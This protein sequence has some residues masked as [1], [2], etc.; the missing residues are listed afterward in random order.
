MQG[1]QLQGVQPQGVHLLR[2][3][4]AGAWRG[5]PTGGRRGARDGH[6]FAVSIRCD[7]ISDVMSDVIHIISDVIQYPKRHNILTRIPM[8]RAVHPYARA[9]ASE[10][11][12]ARTSGLLRARMLRAGPARAHKPGQCTDEVLCAA[13]VRARALARTHARTHTHTHTHTHTQVFRFVD[14]FL[15]NAGV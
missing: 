14:E 11:A 1:G 2:V 7:I 8:C 6:G 3:R 10:R 9:L 4:H 5:R 12:R 13:R 15:R